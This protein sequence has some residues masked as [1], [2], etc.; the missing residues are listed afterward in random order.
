MI[1]FFNF[2]QKLKKKNN[3]YFKNTTIAT[4][5]ILKKFTYNI[6]KNTNFF[7]YKNSKFKNV[8]I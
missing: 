4:N 2:L 7:F 6:P 1:H 5:T 3:K 8:F